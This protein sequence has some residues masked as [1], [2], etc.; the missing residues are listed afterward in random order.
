MNR[1][2]TSTIFAT[3]S[4]S[5]FRGYLAFILLFMITPPLLVAETTIIAFGDST[6]ATRGQLN[7]YTKRLATSPQLLTFDLKIINAGV[8]GNNTNLASKRFDRDVLEHR[9]DIVIIQFGINDA[10]VDVWRTPPA[11]LPRIALSQFEENLKHFITASTSQGTQV[12]LLTPNPI[13]W[14]A[15]LKTLYGKPPYAV[16][17]PNGFNKLLVNYAASVRKLSNEHKVPLVDIYNVFQEYDKQPNQSIDALLLDGMHP[18]ERGHQIIA[19]LLVTE[20]IKILK[21]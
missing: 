20:I 6:T 7:I 9:A 13:R 19:K 5:D 10:A 1:P 15:N 3:E 8:G 16:N 12:I 18:N 14:T 21:R 4:V 17:H 2:L 11:T